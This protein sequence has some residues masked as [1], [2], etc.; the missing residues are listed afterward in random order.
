[1]SERN[2]CEEKAVREIFV[3]ANRTF[4]DRHV[5]TLN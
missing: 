3:I 1:M 4:R 5:V 2:E